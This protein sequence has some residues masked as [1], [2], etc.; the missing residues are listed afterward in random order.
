MANRTN[1][2]SGDRISVAQAALVLGC[3]Y[4]HTRDLLLSG[5]LEGEIDEHNRLWVERSSVE[6]FLAQQEYGN[7]TSESG[8]A[9]GTLPGGE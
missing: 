7:E 8:R 4:Q 3:K 2:S 5:D 9:V 6:R 1:G